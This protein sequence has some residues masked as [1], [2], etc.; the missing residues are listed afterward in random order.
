MTSTIDGMTNIVAGLIAAALAAIIGVFVVEL[1]RGVWERIVRPCL[2]V[3]PRQILGWRPMS[4]S[5]AREFW[6]EAQTF[7]FLAASLGAACMVVLCVANGV[8]WLPVVGMALGAGVVIS[9]G[10]SLLARRRLLRSRLAGGWG[11]R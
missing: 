8:G 3:V 5:E 7:R 9:L 4:E 6:A 1:V 11:I 2:R 10:I